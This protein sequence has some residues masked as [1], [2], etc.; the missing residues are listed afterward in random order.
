MQI[1]CN[2]KS[3]GSANNLLYLFVAKL[4]FENLVT[5]IV[6]IVKKVYTLSSTTQN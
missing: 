5:F 4:E 1:Q 3:H 2:S 6:N